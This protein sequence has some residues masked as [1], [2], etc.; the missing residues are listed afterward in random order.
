[1]RATRPHRH[2]AM[3][4]VKLAAARPSHAV[5]QSVTLRDFAPGAF[6]GTLVA[7]SKREVLQG[8]APCPLVETF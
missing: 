5:Q 4:S 7:R 3:A 6:D 8:W 1:M 2:I